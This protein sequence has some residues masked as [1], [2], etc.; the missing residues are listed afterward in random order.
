MWTDVFPNEKIDPTL[1]ASVFTGV[2]ASLV[3][4]TA[5]NKNGGGA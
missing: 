3:I 5:K 2:L 1:I 4:Q